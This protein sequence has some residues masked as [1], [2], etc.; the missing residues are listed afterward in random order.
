MSAVVALVCAALAAAGGWFVPALI[1]SIPEPERTREPDEPVKERYAALAALPNLA[2]GCAVAS[3]VAAGVLGA[4]LGWEWDLL[5]LVPLCPV[6]VAL[7][8]VDWRTW[9]LPT[10]LIW[11]AYTG[12]L[13]LMV[14]VAGAT[15]EYE[16]LGRA[17]VGQLLAVSLFWLLWRLPGRGMGFGDVR[18]ANVVGL[19]LGHLGWGEWAVGLW[20]GSLL[21]SLAWVPLRLLGRTRSRAFPFGPFLLLGALAGAVVGEVLWEALGASGS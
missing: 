21:G 5:W 15:E 17:V 12:A 6:A 19:T 9:L 8:V 7:A 2:L 4:A 20:L 14:L 11:P 1:G 10:R 16:D 13:V 3:G 18:L